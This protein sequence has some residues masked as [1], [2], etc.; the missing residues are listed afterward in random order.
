M[1]DCSIIIPL[2]DQVG[3]TQRCLETLVAHTDA[4]RYEVV[5]VDNASTDG[6]GELLDRLDGDVTIVR[7]E[8]NLGFATAC[9][10]GADRA[11]TGRLVFVNNDVELL[12]GWLDPLLAPFASGEV[13]AV[14]ARLLFP[15]GTLQHAGVALADDPGRRVLH[16]SHRYYRAQPHLPVANRPGPAA[17]V[18]GALLAVDRVA[19][20]QVGGFDT[21]YWNGLEDVDLCLALW[22]AGRTVLYEPRST[23]IHHESVSGPERFARVDDNVRRF[24]E[25]WRGRV[26]PVGVINLDGSVT[27]L[28]EQ[29]PP[30]TAAAT[31]APATPAAAAAVG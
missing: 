16:A 28:P 4:S 6:T 21:G 1:A 2:Y 31:A 19:F 11:G 7:N 27:P 15:D 22:A 9:N 26:R 10:Q 18:T 13:G 12:P 25:R 17:A 24:T 3:Y 29:F 8:R 20:E 23:A 5:L 30:L 14:G